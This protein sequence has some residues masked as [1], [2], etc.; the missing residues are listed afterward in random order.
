MA[1]KAKVSRKGKS[2]ARRIR[3][4]KKH[5]A[6]A[7]SVAV[8]LLASALMLFVQLQDCSKIECASEMFIDIDR[9]M[10]G[11]FTV[12]MN[13]A[14]YDSCNP[15]PGSN[16]SVDYA[17]G[18]TGIQSI[19]FRSGGTVF[20]VAAFSA[21]RTRFMIPSFDSGSKLIRKLNLTIAYTDCAGNQSIQVFQ[22]K[23]YEPSYEEFR[24]SG[25]FCAA[26][27]LALVNQA[28]G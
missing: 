1:R 3:P 9:G 23:D 20:N 5:I 10:P 19:E 22:A 13:G 14:S 6:V 2:P 26:C 25:Q 18:G 16:I 4:S 24:P 7:C 27:Y 8:I 21:N 12:V 15:G 17:Q 28:Q 11:N